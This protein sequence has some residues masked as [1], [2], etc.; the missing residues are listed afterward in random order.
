MLDDVYTGSYRYV[1]LM[2][3]PWSYNPFLPFVSKKKYV[4]RFP[5]SLSVSTKRERSAGLDDDGLL[6]DV[7]LI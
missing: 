6:Y 4:V 5:M 7:M 1:P 2:I 3:T